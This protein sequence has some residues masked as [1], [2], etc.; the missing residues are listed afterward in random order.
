MKTVNFYI[1]KIYKTAKE[2]FEKG[3]PLIN[4]ATAALKKAE[5]I[6]K[7]LLIERDNLLEENERL[8]EQNKALLKKLKEIEQVKKE[9]KTY[10]LLIKD[11]WSEIQKIENA[12]KE[13]IIVEKIKEVPQPPKIIEVEKIIEK[14]KDCGELRKTISTLLRQSLKQR[15]KIDVRV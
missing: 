11:L 12:P 2:C 4:A 8:R 9:N 10:R 6:I 7:E 13:K 3:E 15:Q 5:E 14:E 1:K